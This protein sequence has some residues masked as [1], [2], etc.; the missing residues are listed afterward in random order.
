[1]L[2]DLCQYF[3][4]LTLKSKLYYMLFNRALHD[5]NEKVWLNF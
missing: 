4:L 2:D 3:S 5:V 1:M